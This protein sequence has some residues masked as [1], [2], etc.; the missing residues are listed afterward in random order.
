MIDGSDNGRF[1]TTNN[2]LEKN[3]TCGS[4]SYPRTKDETVWLLNN[5]H[6]G[7][8]LTRYIPE[9]EE[10]DFAQTSSDTKKRNINKTEEYKCFHYGDKNKWAHECPKL[11]D[12]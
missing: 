1:G 7:K 8:K 2:Y 3:M 5:Y 9:K 10:F 11:Y 12:K 4:D 6:V